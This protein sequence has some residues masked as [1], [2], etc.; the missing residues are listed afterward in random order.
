MKKVKS[1]IRVQIHHSNN[2]TSSAYEWLNSSNLESEDHRVWQLLWRAQTPN[3]VKFLVWLMMH[4]S[5]P[6]NAH[7]MT[8]SLSVFGACVYSDFN[9]HTSFGHINILLDDNKGNY[10]FISQIVF[11]K[12]KNEGFKSANHRQFTYKLKPRSKMNVHVTNSSL[13]TKEII[14]SSHVIP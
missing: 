8:C 12:H 4:G 2:T 3:K 11:L 9:T 10:F 5:L 6:M 14:D 1:K 7:R 13:S